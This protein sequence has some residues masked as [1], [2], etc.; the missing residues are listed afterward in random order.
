MSDPSP[1]VEGPT[2]RRSR[3]L[4]SVRHRPRIYICAALMVVIYFVLP[5]DIR[6]AT[7]AL[8]A[9]NVG[10][11]V[12]SAL[13]G[14]MM[15]RSSEQSIRAHAAIEDERQ[16]VLLVVGAVAAF[17]S[18]G[19]IVSEL[20]E[21]KDMVGLNK[22]AHIAL[23]AATIVTAWTFIHLLFTVHYAHEYYADDDDDLATPGVREG[24]KFPGEANP[25]YGDFLYFSFV[26]GCASQTADVETV[27]RVM[28]QT[29]LAHG[30]VSFFFNT[31]ILALTIN[32]GAGLV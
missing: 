6:F 31:V 28:R 14:W 2:R 7:R 22:A 15:A 3:V 13:V 29:T 17:A 26:I 19:A 20:G 18:L 8:I 9:W 27:S 11:L 21:V 32:I 10:A 12:F 5:Q 30:I 16:W 4:D 23:V 25:T 1:A 24:L